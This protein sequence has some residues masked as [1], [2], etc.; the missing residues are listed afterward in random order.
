MLVGDLRDLLW[1]YELRVA[2]VKDIYVYNY[3][4]MGRMEGAFTRPLAENVYLRAGA[5]VLAHISPWSRPEH[6]ADFPHWLVKDRDDDAGDQQDEDR[7][8]RRDTWRGKPRGARRRSRART[9]HEGRAT[10]AGRG[11]NY[12]KPPLAFIGLGHVFEACDGREDEGSWNQPS[13]GMGRMPS[14]IIT[15]AP[16]PGQ[17]FAKT[18]AGSGVFAGPRPPTP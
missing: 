17:D 3:E 10:E 2:D 15:Q 14:W 4:R 11:H 8:D 12:A 7:A 1:R 6:Y 18:H 5:L 13:S 9:G 16:D